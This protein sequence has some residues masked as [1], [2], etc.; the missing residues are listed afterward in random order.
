MKTITK[1]SIYQA[2]FA[3]NLLTWLIGTTGNRVATLGAKVVIIC[4][5]PYEESVGYQW[6]C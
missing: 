6:Y 1:Q 3:G 2:F 5:Y 4:L